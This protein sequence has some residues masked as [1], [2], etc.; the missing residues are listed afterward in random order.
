MTNTARQAFCKRGNSAG[1]TPWQIV[2][3]LQWAEK[4]GKAWRRAVTKVYGVK[5]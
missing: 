4:Q 1:F 2:A 5:F 3:A